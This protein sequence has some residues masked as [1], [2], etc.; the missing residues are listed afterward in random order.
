[1]R[2]RL[3]SEGLDRTYRQS[4]TSMT[5]LLRAGIIEVLADHLNDP[6]FGDLGMRMP[7]SLITQAL[8]VIEDVGRVCGVHIATHSEN[9]GV[10]TLHPFSGAAS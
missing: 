3:G 2:W 1:M 5:L 4:E 6:K 7:L 10:M 8:K 9:I